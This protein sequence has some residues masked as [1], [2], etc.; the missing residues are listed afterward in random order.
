MKPFSPLTIRL[1]GVTLASIALL[2]AP[3]KTQAADLFT[4]TA[5]GGPTVTVGAN[6]VID[7]I[8][9]AVNRSDAFAALVGG[10]TGSLSYAGV[11]NAITYTSAAAGSSS[12]TIPS[13]GFSKN[14]ATTQALTDFLKTDGSAEVAKFLK[15]M[16][17]QSLVAITDGNPNASTARTAA[18]AFQNYGMS[19]AQTK[20]EKDAEKPNSSRVGFGIIAD[21]G[22]FDANGL[23]GS[24]YSLPM[25]A[26]F[27]LT[28]RV[29]LDFNLPLNYTKIEGAEAF[30][31]GL[32]LAV[33]VK[34]IPRTKDSP[35]YWQLTPFGGA[36]ASASKDLAAGGLLANGGLNSLV[37]YDFGNFAL[38]MGNHLSVYE[39]IPITVSGYT[40]DPGVSQ[41]MLKNGLKLDVPIGQR[42]IFDVYAVHTKF[43]TSAAL[44]QYVT[45]GGEIGYRFLGKA[46]A[47]KKS[48][49]YMKLGLYADVGDNYTSAHA[50]FGTGWKF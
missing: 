41:Q 8:E 43:L 31:L 23:K 24:V 7:L 18:D 27:K 4:I 30:G 37:T 11:A 21:V 25:F 47:A 49:G 26:R 32:G 2:T 38:S 22:S 12:I 15:A 16:A 36:N 3:V 35:W 20:E 40:F 13:T 29:G 6:N 34:V 10:V 48:G 14:F 46:N 5:T 17:A 42:W 45:L 1:V 44:D 50:Q 9:R 28:D 39:G 33:P 19:F